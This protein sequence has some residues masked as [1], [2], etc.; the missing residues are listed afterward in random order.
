MCGATIPSSLISRL[1]AVQDDSETVRKIGID[2]ATQQCEA[3]LMNGAPGI[4]FYTLN[5][6]KSTLH[7]L[8]NIK[9]QVNPLQNN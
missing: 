5:R 6:S 2:H 1:E 4:H 3:L 9:S 8:E 7:I